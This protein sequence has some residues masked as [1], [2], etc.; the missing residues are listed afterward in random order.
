M[1]CG[2]FNCCS[3]TSK[4]QSIL[5]VHGLQQLVMS[6]TRLASTTGSP[7]DLVV[8]SATY[9]KA[10]R[11][12][13]RILYSPSNHYCD[14]LLAADLNPQRIYI[15][16]V[17][18][19]MK[20]VASVVI[21]LRLDYCNSVPYGTSQANLQKL[22]GVQNALAHLVW[23]KSRHDNITPV[24]ANLHWLSMSTRIYHKVGL[25]TFKA[26]STDQPSYLVETL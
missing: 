23:S 22:Q 2:Y 12:T 13:K 6:P 7:L 15:L 16:F 24:L 20:T 5:D 11:A 21:S 1:A 19:S 17:N 3:I 18:V 10:C 14:H 4:L 25:L 8:C 9:Q 26:I